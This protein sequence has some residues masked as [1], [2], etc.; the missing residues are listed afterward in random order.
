MYKGFNLTLDQGSAFGMQLL[1]KYVDQTTVYKILKAE[2]KGKISDFITHDG[3][4]DAKKLEQAWFQLI[5]ADVFISHSHADEALAIAVAAALDKEL[6]LS[7]FIDS[8][9]WGNADV[10][11]K[12]IDNKYCLRSNGETYDYDKRNRST[13]H[14]HMMLQGAL[15]KMIDNTECIIFLNTPS[16]MAANDTL[17]EESRTA[18][19]WIYAE[20]LATQ[21]IRKKIPVR[22]AEKQVMLREKYADSE[23]AMDEALRFYHDLDL[24]HLTKLSVREFQKWLSAGRQGVGTAAL[25]TLYEA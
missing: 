3:G 12:E 23:M 9:V 11:L 17:T 10:L 8:C 14:V 13:S 6:G 22:L 21:L 7:C 18:S 2:A 19:P 20:V 4:I 24:S 15:A 25:D 5:K 1:E 16:S